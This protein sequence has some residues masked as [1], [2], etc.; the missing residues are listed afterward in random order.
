MV[1]TIPLPGRAPRIAPGSSVAAPLPAQAL[2]QRAVALS[3]GGDHAAAVGAWRDVLR[4]NPADADAAHELGRAL[5]ALARR[6]EAIEAFERALHYAPDALDPKIGMGQAQLALGRPADARY[7]FEDVVAI[8]PERPEAI[9]GLAAALRATGKAE[10]ALRIV[11]NGAKAV[12]GNAEIMLEQGQ[13]LIALKRDEEA[14]AMLAEACKAH[15]GHVELGLALGARYQ[16]AERWRD[17]MPVLRKVVDQR[18]DDPTVWFNYAVCCRGAG[19]YG[20][21]ATALRHSILLKPASA[22]AYAM[23]ALVLYDLERFDEAIAAANSALA[24]EPDSGGVHFNKG[25][26]HLTRGEWEPGWEGYECRW[27]KNRTR[28]ARDDIL[29]APWC[30]EPIEGKS[31][32]LLGEQANGDYL[33]FA[34]YAKALAAL[35]AKVS[36]LAPKRLARL[37]RSLGDV[38]ILADLTPGRR[39]DYQCHLLSVPLRLHRMGVPIPT[40]PYLAAEPTLV[41]R[42]RDRIGSHGFRIGIA[43]QGTDYGGKT[44][45]RSYALS[46]AQHLA[47]L[48]GVRLISLQ[49][50]KGTEQIAALGGVMTVEELGGEFDTGGDAFVDTAAVMES[51]DLIVTCDTSIAHLAGAMHRPAWVALVKNA[52]WRWQRDVERS[53]WYPSARLFRQTTPGDWDAVFR[54]MGSALADHL[55]MARR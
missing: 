5:L 24:I 36:F 35:G 8:A 2:W 54:T 26:I 44:G 51:L 18:P 15:P 19:E 20:D 46:N 53:V 6:E 40:D 52:E 34:R 31:I 45:S 55:S 13:C 22:A 49:I 41:E 4:A 17:G 28:G 25:I 50:G 29:A 47:A 33:H 16:A 48:D 3:Q 7:T 27:S 37:L 42:W 23:L 39:H 1:L 43:W 21:A 32:L 9:A 38:E 10:A 12:P 14:T 11:E 30:G